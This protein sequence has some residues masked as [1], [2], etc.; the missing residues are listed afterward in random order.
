MQQSP[1]AGT[2]PRSLSSINHQDHDDDE[3]DGDD[4]DHDDI[5][6]GWPVSVCLFVCFLLL[7]SPASIGNSPGC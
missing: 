4:H 3:D 1:A 7:S 5:C 6:K 2:S